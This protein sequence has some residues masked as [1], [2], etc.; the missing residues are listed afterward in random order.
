MERDNDFN[1]SKDYLPNF[2]QNR[3]VIATIDPT[4]TDFARNFFLL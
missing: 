3:F 2:A 4:V 1:L